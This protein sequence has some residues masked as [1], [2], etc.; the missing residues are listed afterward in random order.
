[1]NNAVEFL[2]TVKS[3]LRNTFESYYNQ[4]K[5]VGSFDFNK[6][7]SDDEFRQSIFILRNLAKQKGLDLRDTYK[8]NRTV[9]EFIMDIYFENEEGYIKLFA[10]YFFSLQ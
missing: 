8:R 5:K 7:V 2:D 10:R 6:F 3:N 9:E 4:R 1:M